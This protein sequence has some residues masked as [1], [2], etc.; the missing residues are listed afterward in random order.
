VLLWAELQRKAMCKCLKGPWAFLK[1]C[2]EEMVKRTRGRP[3][4]ER[5]LLV[6]VSS[7]ASA[8]RKKKK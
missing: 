6:F 5:V 8:E 1:S 7:K 3:A 2:V 4:A